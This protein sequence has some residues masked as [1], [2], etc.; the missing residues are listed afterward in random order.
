MRMHDTDMAGILYF[1]R[2]FRFVH[3][4]FE[5][6]IESEGYE[7]NSLF[8]KENSFLR[9]VHVEADYLKSLQVGDRLEVHL[10]IERIG[11]SSITFI[12]NIYRNNEELVGRA[13]TIHVYVNRLTGEKTRIPDHYRQQFSKYLV[14]NHTNKVTSTSRKD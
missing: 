12:Y 6:L 8:K 7:M 5:D 1:A 13:K 10:G 14:T 11:N 9:I 2:Q 4:A 3:D